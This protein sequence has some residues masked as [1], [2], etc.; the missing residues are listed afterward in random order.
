MI[1][2]RMLAAWSCALVMLSA[3]GAAFAQDQVARPDRP[4]WSLEIKGGRF[5]PD[6]DN[7]KEFYGNDSTTQLGLGFG[8]KVLR[9]LEVGAEASFIRDKG[10]GFLPLNQMPGGEVT[11]TLVPVDVFV[12]FRGVFNENQWVVP[13][14][15]G[16]WTRAFYKQEIK[17]QEDVEGKTDGYNARLGI[18]LLIDNM[19]PGEANSAESRVGL[20][21]TYLYLEAKTFSAKKNDVELGGTSY[22]LGILLEF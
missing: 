5:F 17:N 21:N 22:L 3:V 20:D 16:G 13:Y 10:V 19:V 18:Q 15:G 14:I 12:L 1:R 2:V 8:Y 9:Q 7:W 6:L 11:W 4:H